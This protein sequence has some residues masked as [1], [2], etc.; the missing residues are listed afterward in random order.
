MGAEY[1]ELAEQRDSVHKWL[2]SEEEG[3]G[4][5]LQQ[6]SALL[7]E[8]IERA[9]QQGAEG[10][11]AADAFLLHDT[12]GF[13]FDL[14]LELVAEHGLGVDEEGFESLM[15]NQRRKSRVTAG[16]GAGRRGTA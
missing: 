6:G 5:T 3:F 2:A 13:P 14:T 8:L 9:K 16:R 15:E 12:H 10:I 11:A 1:G 7:D 4:R